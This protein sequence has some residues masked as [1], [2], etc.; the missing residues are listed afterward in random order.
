[1][2]TNGASRWFTGTVI[3]MALA[4]DTRR[5]AWNQGSGIA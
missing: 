3:Q 2:T 5:Q 1:M 4:D